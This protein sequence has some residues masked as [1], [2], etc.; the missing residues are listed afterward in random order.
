MEMRF[1]SSH[2]SV[3]SSAKLA[4]ALDVGI[5]R[6]FVFGR[7]CTPGFFSSVIAEMASWAALIQLDRLRGGGVL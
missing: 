1:M 3:S 7:A 6:F 4:I 2:P 5:R